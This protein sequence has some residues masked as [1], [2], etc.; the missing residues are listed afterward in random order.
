MRDKRTGLPA[1]GAW[2]AVF[3]TA[4]FAFIAMLSIGIL[5]APV[6]I[7]LAYLVNARFRSSPE[8]T[9]GGPVGAGTIL[10]WIAYRHRD[11]PGPCPGGGAMSRGM[12]V[13][14]AGGR[15]VM[16]LEMSCGGLDPRPWLAV[17]V[18]LVAIGLGVALA[19]RRRAASR[20]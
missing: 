11:Y 4:T 15:S 2:A 9:I 10:L 3:A 16:K 5:V 1:A 8:S 7:G 6:A 17:G 18:L 12:E 20:G 14:S 19:H 13:V